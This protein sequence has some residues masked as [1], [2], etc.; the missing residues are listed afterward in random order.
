[1]ADSRLGMKR[2]VYAPKVYAF[3]H[4]STQNKIYNLSP[5][6]V[7]GSVTRYINQ[8]SKATIVLR[9]RYKKWLRDPDNKKSIFLPMDMITI[10]L[11][12]VAGKPI[13]V[14]TGYL[15]TVPY[16]QMYPG[17]CQL[18]A[19]CTLKKL[20]T[21]YFDPGTTFFQNWI[22]HLKGWVM[23]PDGT[24]VNQAGRTQV[25]TNDPGQNL[26]DGGFAQMINDFMIQIANWRPSWVNVDQLNP[27]IPQ[28]A[29]NL[30]ARIDKQDQSAL[31]GLATIMN[32]VLGVSF[33]SA[34][35]QANNPNGPSTIPNQVASSMT[36]MRKLGSD[37]D[38]PLVALATAAQLGSGFKPDYNQNYNGNDTWGYGLYGLKPQLT[39]VSRRSN[40]HRG[41]A[42]TVEATTIDGYTK[43]E[44]MNVTTATTDM[45]ARLRSADVARGPGT[46]NSQVKQGDFKSLKNWLELALDTTFADSTFSGAVGTAQTY[47]G[48]WGAAHPGEYTNEPLISKMVPDK[49]SRL[50]WGSDEVVKYRTEGDDQQIYKSV[51]AGTNDALAPYYWMARSNYKTLRLQASLPGVTIKPNVLIMSGNINEIE[52]LAHSLGPHTRKDSNG[53]KA[54]QSVTTTGSGI[55]IWENGVAQ[56]H[57]A[58]GSIP[59]RGSIVIETPTDA[60]ILAYPTWD[61]QAV[62]THQV[63]LG[64]NPNSPTATGTAT[65][66]GNRP[67]VRAEDVVAMSMAS[68]FATQMEFPTNQ[69][70]A[71]L[72]TGYKA[73]ENDI[74]CLEGVDQ[75]CQA[76]LRNFMSLPNGQFLA[77][78]PDYFGAHGR[79]AYW[80]IYDIEI[81]NAGV[82]LS[83]IPLSTHVYATGDITGADGQI[84][85]LDRIAS[86]GAV[87]LDMPLLL[88]SFIQ[89]GLGD[90]GENVN[91]MGWAPGNLRTAYDFYNHF[92]IRVYKE[93]VPII[94]NTYY[95]FLYAW[96]R[97]MQKWAETFQT[98]IE[99]TFQ[100][101]VLAGGIVCF[102]Q[103]NLQ[104][105][106]KSVTHNFDY[107]SGFTTNAEL[108]A[109]AAMDQHKRKLTEQDI[110]SLP[111][112][113]IGGNVNTVGAV[114]D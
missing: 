4:S 63:V 25:P 64:Q 54:L 3:V 13:Q 45:I 62:S 36:I 84:T 79:Q 89:P 23:L 112:F 71:Q 82:Q 9:N 35:N 69:I 1:M 66:G 83:D 27:K 68:A 108:M 114:A 106:V 73:F 107:G 10:W 8:E 113:A 100:P 70:E 11:Q 59:N 28:L 46:F 85:I 111:G 78:Y 48:A 99:F 93:D 86:H 5:D 76:S 22:S 20:A 97:F 26:N 51:Y 102:P 90:Q 14:F 29:A 104:M 105:F 43:K 42:T 96:Q 55:T 32:N 75:F 2:L 58:V 56:T 94:R 52:G 31:Q 92:G 37:K 87:T 15:D 49:V 109:P 53:K 12:R 95:E 61:G 77:F 21:T 50:T 57:G 80:P 74:T 91:E 40:S 103:H 7:S 17:N 110:G 39:S 38:I 34:A 65:S 47:M 24:A 19:T 72:L 60:K 41:G 16:Y 81:T 30:Y 67:D 33:N 101:E 98:T 88:R 18:E 6:I 44:M